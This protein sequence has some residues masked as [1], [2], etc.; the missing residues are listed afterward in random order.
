MS[1]HHMMDPQKYA[2]G[3]F[4][5]QAYLTRNIHIHSSSLVYRKYFQDVDLCF[6]MLQ[7]SKGNKNLVV[8]ST[9]FLV[10][11]GELANL[12]GNFFNLHEASITRTTIETKP[13]EYYSKE[14]VMEGLFDRFRKIP[15]ILEA[16][17]EST[18]VGLLSRDSK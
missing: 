5:L 2:L 17:V 18:I 14:N 15:N 4:V 9:G 10:E 11:L 8:E 12:V 7:L 16:Q 6:L 3:N 1:G 13:D